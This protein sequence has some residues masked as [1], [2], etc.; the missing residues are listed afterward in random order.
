MG[1]GYRPD[2][3]RPFLSFARSFFDGAAFSFAPFGHF[4]GQLTM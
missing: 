2:F 4:S 3:R 1:L